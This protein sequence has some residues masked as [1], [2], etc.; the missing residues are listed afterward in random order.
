MIFGNF[1]TLNLNYHANVYICA[2]RVG[3][4]QVGF[5]LCKPLNFWQVTTG[6]H[7]LLFTEEG[8]DLFVLKLYYVEQ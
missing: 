5:W 2:W 3:Q 7:L 8:T 6:E 1:Q 4:S